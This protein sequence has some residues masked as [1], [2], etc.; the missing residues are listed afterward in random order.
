MEL[1]AKFKKTEVGV[2][3]EDWVVREFSEHFSIY[4]GGD[5]PKQSFSQIQ[6]KSHP[7]PI[8]ANA[9]QN[10][11]L[12]GYTSERRSKSDSL[13]ITARGYLGHAEYRSQPFFPIVRL[14]VLEPT[15]GMDAKFTAY[16][17]NDRVK[18]PIES[19][20]VPQ[21][22][23]PQVRK[24]SVALPPTEAE[25]RAIATV[26]SNVDA[27]LT[28]QK[29][30]LAKKRDIKQAIMQQLLTGKH[31]LS[32]FTEKWKITRLGDIASF[33]KGKGL[34]KNELDPNG[35]EPCIHYGEL[36]TQYPEIISTILS[37]TNTTDC[38]FRSVA[39]DVLMPTS[40]V[41]PNGLAK[42]SCI[43]QSEVILGGDILI[44]RSNP[45]ILNGS[46]LS[47]VIRYLQEQ[48]MRL[49][50]G[51]TVFHLYGID[52]KKFEFS[53]PHYDEQIAIA[54]VLS[55]IDADIIALEKQSD[56]TSAIKQGMMQELLTGRIRLV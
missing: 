32:G 11:G 16:I 20:G 29:K 34:S 17:V 27:L 38:V 36:F 31:R 21:L 5:V 30:L 44:I 14:L 10:K 40:D 24:H 43:K 41:T 12:Y 19:T 22:T 50:S 15:G 18:F 42:A 2:I 28:A 8:F 51:T 3:P 39:N 4:A 25:Q 1:R 23:V 53:M 6:S 33:Y 55:D 47:Y 49:V 7:Y 52:M 26:L 46:F 37:H 48:I 45:K 13:T 9:L 35:S 56:K 54:T